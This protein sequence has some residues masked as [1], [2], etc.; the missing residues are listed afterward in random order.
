MANNDLRSEM[1][2]RACDSLLADKRVIVNWAT[3]SGKSRVAINAI[4]SLVNHGKKRF[5]LLVVESAHKANWK[6]EFV[7]AEGDFI[8]TGLFESL[9]VECYAS[10]PKYADTE[11]DLIIADEAHHLRSDARCETLRTMRSDRV[12]CLSATI[13][14]RGD[15]DNLMQTLTDT[16]GPFKS[17]HFNL[18]DA[19]DMGV[20]A[21]PRIYIHILDMN[22]F[23]VREFVYERGFKKARKLYELDTEHKARTVLLDLNKYRNIRA[24]VRLPMATAYA[25]IEDLIALLK[26]E[27]VSLSNSTPDDAS[28]SAKRRLQSAYYAWMSAGLLRKRFLA[29][30]KTDYT[31]ALLSRL[32]DKKY[33]CFCND[34]EQGVELG[35]DNI[36]HSKRT[37]KQNEKIIDDFN[38]GVSKSLFA[39]GMLQEG[40]NLAG[41]EAGVIVQLDGKER[42]FVQKFGR[43]LRA[44]SPQQHIV[45][46]KHTQDRKYFDNAYENIDK[47]YL[48]FVQPKV[49]DLERGLFDIELPNY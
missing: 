16:F 48:R 39:V 41:I 4:T 2:Q 45:V 31:R 19:I 3:G 21:Q 11:W 26:R 18:Q 10:L 20:L 47:S 30:S 43:A 6:R 35:G 49:I 46:F 33:I 32:S 27:Y 38:N 37:A 7:D 9:T 1:Q 44:A 8:G 15:G 12:L 13:N 17:L 25:I 14:E 40:A 22:D 36:I 42:P 24:V 29:N 5:L 23:G 28:E 34:V